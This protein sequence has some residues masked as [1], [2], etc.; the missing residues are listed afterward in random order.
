MDRE[1]S[2]KAK[3]QIEG[4]HGDRRTRGQVPVTTRE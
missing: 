2:L 1:K 3:D 4:G